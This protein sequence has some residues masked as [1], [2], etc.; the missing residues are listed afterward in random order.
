[1]AGQ[2]RLDG[3]FCDYTLEDKLKYLQEAYDNGVR[4]IEMECVS[5][6]AM[7]N[8]AQIPAAVMCVTL[9]DRLKGDQVVL[10]HDQHSDFQS[11]PLKIVANYIKKN[12]N[13]SNVNS[14]EWACLLLA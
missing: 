14:A 2:G 5:F 4:N 8:R 10:T 6:A 13:H 9:L 11:R 3:A 12:W 1:M 7:C